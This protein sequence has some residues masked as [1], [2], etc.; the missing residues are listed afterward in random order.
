MINQAVQLCKIPM[1]DHCTV[2][3]PTST[4]SA[5]HILRAEYFQHYHPSQF[6]MCSR[7]LLEES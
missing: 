2:F 6:C 1:L 4:Q 3:T 5:F 7:L